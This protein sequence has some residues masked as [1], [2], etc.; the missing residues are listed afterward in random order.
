[1]SNSLDSERLVRSTQRL[2]PTAPNS[3]MFPS[4]LLDR[5]GRILGSGSVRTCQP[6]RQQRGFSHLDIDLSVPFV[7]GLRSPT[8]ALVRIIVILV[9]RH[10][11]TPLNYM[12][13]TTPFP[14][15][16]KKRSN[17]LTSETLT[18]VTRRKYVLVLF[19]CR[20]VTATSHSST[21]PVT[22]S[23]CAG[24]NT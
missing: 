13:L 10:S 15:S 4:E 18:Q 7:F 21:P 16:Y 22:S 14:A 11:T 1:M 20:R 2:P 23:F 24:G 3:K 19:Y 6:C 8:E 17:R 9:S 5:G 12:L